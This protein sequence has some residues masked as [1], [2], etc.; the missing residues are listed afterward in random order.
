MHYH[1]LCKRLAT[2]AFPRRPFLT[3]CNEIGL[4]LEG[5]K[6]PSCTRILEIYDLKTSCWSCIPVPFHLSTMACKG[7]VGS[8]LD[9]QR[10][11]KK[12]KLNSL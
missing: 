12:K 6:S 10:V 2:H 8:P 3:L 5:H 7:P 4:M 1:P 11:K 9:T